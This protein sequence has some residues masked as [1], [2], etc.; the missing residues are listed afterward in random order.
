MVTPDPRQHPSAQQRETGDPSEQVQPMPLL[1]AAVT[2]VMVL[3]GAAY[4]FFSD[5]FGNAELGDRRTVADLMAKAPGAPGTTQAVDGKALY[6]SNCV[7]CHQASGK[8]LP[9]V[10][11]PLDGSEW[12][13]G[14]AR[15]LVNILLHGINGEIEVAGTAYKGLM[16]PFKQLGDAE[17]AAIASTIRSEWSNKAV[18]ITPEQFAA[19]RKDTRRT[20]PFA[21]GAELK[22]LPATQ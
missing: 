17:L 8:G 16:P 10:F 14:D 2:L 20:A 11:P 15:V 12:V 4:I 5:P 22:A 19:E 21:S 18:A 1:A 7:A 6:A 13:Q 9:G 3:L